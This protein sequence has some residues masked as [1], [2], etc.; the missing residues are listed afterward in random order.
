MIKLGPR[1]QSPDPLRASRERSAAVPAEPEAVPDDIAMTAL[2]AAQVA[3]WEVEATEVVLD[4]ADDWI[5][6]H[7]ASH[8][9]YRQAVERRRLIEARWCIQQ[10]VVW[11]A[12]CQLWYALGLMTAREAWLAENA[13]EIDAETLETIWRSLMG[14]RQ[15]P[16]GV[17]YPVEGQLPV[18]AWQREELAERRD[19]Q[20]AKEAKRRSRS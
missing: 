8:R 19:K 16:F 17:V 7:A 18:P 6:G 15:I 9:L 20:R 10:R 3:A 14:E 11:T 4:V 2:L 1:L 5:A 13:P 12:C